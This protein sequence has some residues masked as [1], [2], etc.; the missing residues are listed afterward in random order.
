MV[1]VAGSELV[2]QVAEIKEGKPARN[3]ENERSG[4]K[5]KHKA[6]KIST[7]AMYMPCTQPT[8]I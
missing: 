6:G 2:A 3:E 7:V 8:Q 1:D 5:D 4:W